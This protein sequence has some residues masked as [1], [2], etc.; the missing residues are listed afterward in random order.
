MTPTVISLL[1]WAPFLLIAVICGV[2]FALLGY[3]R[4]T[5]RALISLAAT[6]L[7]AVLSVIVARL[8]APYPATFV[9][10]LVVNAIG[11]DYAAMLQGGHVAALVSGLATAACALVIFLPVFLLVALIVK[12]VTSAVF[13]N[14]LPQ[15]KKIVNNLGGMAISVVDALLFALLLLLPLY[16]TLGLGNEVYTAVAS[17]DESLAEQ[18]EMVS[19]IT[20]NPLSKTANA[21]PC[22]LVYDNLLSFSHEG[23]N[24]SVSQTVRGVSHIAAGAAAFGNLGSGSAEVNAQVIAMLNETEKL[25]TDNTFFVGLVCDVAETIGQTEDSAVAQM[26]SGYNG[27]S[28]K[29]TLHGDL[30]ALFNVLLAVLC[31][32]SQ[33][34]RQ[35]GLLQGLDG[36]YAG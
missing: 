6:L 28:D 19:S 3:K 26:L 36:Q 9:E 21:G 12:L 2:S 13:R 18:Q 16:G 25:L 29:D 33:Q 32:S 5:P 15:P 11:S 24:I 35:S 4:G 27:L 20:D 23:E 17:M 10:S 34:H 7:S 30:P 8:V 14:I 31:R 1:V 22:A